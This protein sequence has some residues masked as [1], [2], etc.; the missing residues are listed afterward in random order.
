M[1][2]QLDRNPSTPDALQ[3]DSVSGERDI[4]ENDEEEM[5]EADLDSKPTHNQYTLNQTVEGK[6]N[7]FQ[8]DAI[9]NFKNNNDNNINT[10]HGVNDGS[11]NEEI[12]CR[13]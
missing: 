7:S 10:D 1:E 8:E 11:E 12:I 6:G 2:Q 4:K 9:N 13:L 3:Y 5:R